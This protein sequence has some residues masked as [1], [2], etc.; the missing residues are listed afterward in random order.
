M[1]EVTPRR[2]WSLRAS[3]GGEAPDMPHGAAGLRDGRR[4]RGP[5]GGSGSEITAWVQQTFPE[6]GGRVTFYDLTP[7]K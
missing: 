5:G 1:S 2:P 6:V 7:E 4:G 3:G